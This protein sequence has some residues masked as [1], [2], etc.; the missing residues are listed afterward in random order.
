[1]VKDLIKLAN[2]LDKIGLS[3]RSDVIDNI[4]LKISEKEEWS[5]NE[6]ID[7]TKYNWIPDEDSHKE[8]KEPAVKKDT[9]IFDEDSSETG[10]GFGSKILYQETAN[11]YS[12][13]EYARDDSG[14]YVKIDYNGENPNHSGYG[15]ATDHWLREDFGNIPDWDSNKK[16]R[17]GDDFISLGVI[18]HFD[19]DE[20][21]GQPSQVEMH[22]LG[23]PQGEESED[24]TV[25][26]NGLI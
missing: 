20:P 9:S 7:D 2:H 4:I 12:I 1:M 8:P 13:T 11:D 15:G 3:K 25:K 23:Y 14:Q 21:S 26:S 6:E 16:F 24:F 18:S 19:P 22:V 5:K 10:R 17:P